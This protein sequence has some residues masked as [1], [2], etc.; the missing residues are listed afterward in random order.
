LPLALIA[1]DAWPLRRLS[2]ATVLEK[3]PFLALSGAS[4][5]I[6]I[7]AVRNTWEF[8]ALPPLDVPAMLTRVVWL[9]GFYLGKVFWP[10]GLSTVYASPDVHA[11]TRPTVALPIAGGVLAAAACIVLRKRQPG[12]LAGALVA[13]ILLTPTFAL[14][15]YSPVIAYDRYLH[16][17]AL[18]L[19]VAL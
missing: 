7:L 10:A 3:W 15:R 16:L 2:M 13:L 6:S 1:L 12:L 5:V 18:G 9:Q 17:P 14:L 11:L 8:G 19:A 4:A